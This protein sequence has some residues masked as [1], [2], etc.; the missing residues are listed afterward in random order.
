MKIRYVFQL[1]LIG[2]VCWL[3]V[4]VMTMVSAP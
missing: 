4:V 1:W 2:M 3:I